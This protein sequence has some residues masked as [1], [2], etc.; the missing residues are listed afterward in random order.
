MAVVEDQQGR[1]IIRYFADDT[2]TRSARDEAALAAALGAIGAFC[3]LDWDEV[4]EGL[5]RIRHE[6]P[7]TPPINDL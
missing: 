2:P 5:D 4:Q 7:P 1:E 3:D 6:S